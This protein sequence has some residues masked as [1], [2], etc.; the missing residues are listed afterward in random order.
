MPKKENLLPETRPRE[1]QEKIICPNVT[2]ELL[3]ELLESG[4][5]WRFGKTK[6]TVRPVEEDGAQ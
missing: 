4:G 5:G 2:P 1:F 3:V 6:K